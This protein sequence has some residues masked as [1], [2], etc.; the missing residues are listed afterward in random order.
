MSPSAAQ[1][2]TGFKSLLAHSGE[3]LVREGSSGFRGVVNRKV[4][5]ARD[6]LALKDGALDFDWVGVV[7]IEFLKA[8][9]TDVAAGDYIE[10]ELDLQ[11]RVRAVL[12]TDITFVCYCTPSAA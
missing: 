8:A 10:D 12:A 1:R 6:G 2:I 4:L 9:L 7:E 3:G 5:K 11:H